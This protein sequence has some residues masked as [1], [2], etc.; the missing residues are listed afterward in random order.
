MKQAGFEIERKFLITMPEENWLSQKASRRLSLVQ[1]YLKGAEKE[2]A[3]V[4]QITENGK[5]TYVHTVKR[6]ISAIK[7]EETEKE[8]SE[9]MYQDLLLSADADRR[10]IRKTRYCMPYDGHILEIDIFPFWKDKAF[11]EV[12]L[13]TEEEAFTLPE[14]ICVLREVTADSRYTNAALARSLPE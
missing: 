3:R 6:R 9:K 1:T 13:S 4:R 10:P 12:E 8:I 11:L 5:T 14:E 7:R 2:S